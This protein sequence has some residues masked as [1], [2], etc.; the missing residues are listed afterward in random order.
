[1]ATI[2][3][4]GAALAVL[5]WIGCSAPLTEREK[6][7]LGGAVLGAGTGAII[8]QATGKGAGKGAAIGGGLGALGGG[9]IGHQQEQRAQ[10]GRRQDEVLDRQRQEIA[11]NRE[12]IEELRRRDLDAR[13]TDRG[14]VVN[15]PDVLFEFAR[16]D[17]TPDARRKVREMADVLGRAARDRR[18]AVEGHT[19]SIGSDEYNQ[20]LSEARAETVASGLAAQGIERRRLAV[21]GFGKRYPVAPNT[22]NGR[23][24][25][26]GRARNRRVEVVIEN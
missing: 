18:V 22:V 3:M 14:V 25:P 5:V 7:A 23:D 4:S 2:R 24:N 16:A 9:L 13:E 19:D 1:M 11:R 26:D 20:R 15:L 21:R 8:G 17:L 6:G 10:E 12:L